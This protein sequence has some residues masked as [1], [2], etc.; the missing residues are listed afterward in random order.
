MDRSMINRINARFADMGITWT[1]IIDVYRGYQQQ[2]LTPF[3]EMTRRIIANGVTPR[4]VRW[5]S[6]P[7][8]D[9][10]RELVTDGLYLAARMLF[11]LIRALLRADQEIV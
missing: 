7:E 4:V 8:S 5:F 10:S 3:L 2:D 11:F 6:I 9:V 1:D